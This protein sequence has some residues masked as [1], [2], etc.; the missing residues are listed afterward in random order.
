MAAAT[1]DEQ[2]I[3]AERAG[4]SRAYMYQL[5]GGHRQASAELGSGIERETR[6]MAKASKGRLPI[7]YRTDI[8]AAC[9]A[10]EFAQ[11]CLG[12]RA[13]VSDFPIIQHL[14]S[15]DTEGGEL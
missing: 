7:V 6:V 2:S 9:R 3:L 13:V 11:K 14:P 1:T 15:V 10:C 5:A 8:V 12:E 4:T